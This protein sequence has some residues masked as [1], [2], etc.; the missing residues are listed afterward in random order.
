MFNAYLE[1]L[2]A[3]CRPGVTMS[4]SAVFVTVKDANLAVDGAGCATIAIGV[5]CDSKDKILMTML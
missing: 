3:M 4:P 1:H 2:T 5:E